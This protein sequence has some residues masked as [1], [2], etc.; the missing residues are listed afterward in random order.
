MLTQKNKYVIETR[1]K[2]NRKN[3]KSN[4]PSLFAEIAKTK[5]IILLL[6]IIKP[7]Y[8]A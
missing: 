3:K 6:F 1:K 4:K 7:G 5:G 2:K 8:I